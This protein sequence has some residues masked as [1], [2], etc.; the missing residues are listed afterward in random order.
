MYKQLTL[1]QRYQISYGLQHK[2]SYRQ[3]AKVVGCSATTIFNEVKRNTGTR[4]YNPRGANKMCR[5]R[6]RRKRK[7]ITITPQVWSIIYFYLKKRFS[8][9][10]ICYTVSKIKELGI[11]PRG[12]YAYIKRH[13]HR[14]DEVYKYL[15]RGNKKY[16]KRSKSVGTIIRKIPNRVS[17]HDRPK[18]IETKEELGHWEADTIQGKGHHTGILTLVERKTAYTVI[19]KLEGKNARCLA[20]RCISTLLPYKEKVKSITFDNGVEFFSHEKIANELECKTYFA[21]PNSPWQRGL[22]E[23]TNGLIRQYFPK[24]TDLKSVAQEELDIVERELN[25][26]PRKRRGFHSPSELF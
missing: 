15:R 19:V 6:H 1:E 14:K 12:I 9:E 10:Q 7:K 24:G 25:L 5:Q 4:G 17:I 2:H 22:N 8:P 20:K 23:N 21:D 13:F 3:I 26:R 18:E 16:R 11:S